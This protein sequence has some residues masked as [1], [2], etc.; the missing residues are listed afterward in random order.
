MKYTLIDCVGGVREEIEAADMEAAKEY[1]ESWMR[2]CEW[3]TSEGTTWVHVRVVPEGEEYGEKIEIAIEPDEPNCTADEGHDWQSPI[4]IVGG[5]KENP[6]VWGH[7]GGVIIHEVCLHC[8]CERVT[9]TWA[10]DRETGRQGLQ[11]VTYNPGKYAA[12]VE[13]LAEEV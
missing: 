8:G 12:E 5:I 2:E 10:Q 7:G 11:S 13:Q 4:S 1:A 3:D 6:G 9:D